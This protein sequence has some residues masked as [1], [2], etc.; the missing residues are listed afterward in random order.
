MAPGERIVQHDGA[1]GTGTPDG[2]ERRLEFRAR[3]RLGGMDGEP[4]GRGSLLRILP[5]GCAKTGPVTSPS[6][7]VS[8]KVRRFMSG[9]L[10]LVV[11]ARAC[12]ACSPAR[13]SRRYAAASLPRFG[14]TC[15]SSRAPASSLSPRTRPRR[16]PSDP[17]SREELRIGSASG[18]GRGLQ[19]SALRTYTSPSAVSRTTRNP[20][21]RYIDS[22]PR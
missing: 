1:V 21:A 16:R 20:A 5:V 2:P 6:P 12:G 18:S 22:G 13:S 19:P 15:T 4:Q 9:F 7:M 14:S 8:M 17:R 11:T 3:S 10:R